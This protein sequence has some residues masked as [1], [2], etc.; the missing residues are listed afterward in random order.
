MFQ[1][2]LEVP[3]P[4]ENSRQLMDDSRSDSG[5]LLYDSARGG[6]VRSRRSSGR[7]PNKC[8]RPPGRRQI[9]VSQILVSNHFLYQNELIPVSPALIEG[10]CYPFS[11]RRSAS[12]CSY[13]A[14]A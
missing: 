12:A 1:N 6:P 11:K 9:L 14:T 13:R 3:F 4:I 7:S 2:F 8:V 10:D 5:D